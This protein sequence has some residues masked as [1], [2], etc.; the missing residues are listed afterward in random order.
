VTEKELQAAVLKLAG[1]TGWLSYHTYDS[2]RST[3]GFPDLI[4][5]RWGR[6]LAVELKSSKGRATPEQLNWLALLSSTGWES[7]L[8]RPSDWIDGTIEAILRGA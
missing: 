6:G 1:Y 7:Y 3:P 4:M 2:R 5:V 8:W